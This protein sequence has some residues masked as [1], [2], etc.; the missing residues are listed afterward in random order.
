MPASVS[1][2]EKSMG[3]LSYMEKTYFNGK[4]GAGQGTP[5]KPEKGK[6]NKES[7]ENSVEAWRP[8]ISVVSWFLDSTNAGL[9]NINFLESQ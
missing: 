6:D 9:I 8:R 7:S 4:H 2:P 1:Q 3:M 5:E